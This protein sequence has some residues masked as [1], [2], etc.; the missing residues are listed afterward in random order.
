M[1]SVDIPNQRWGRSRGANSVWHR[2][3]VQ[4]VVTVFV[5]AW[6][7]AAAQCPPPPVKPVQC[8]VTKDFPLFEPTPGSVVSLANPLRSDARGELKIVVLGDSV[9]WGDGL[10]PEEK[11]VGLFGREIADLTDREVHVIS[12]AHSGARLHK[13]DDMNSV[14]HEIDGHPIGDLDSQRPTT[15]EQHACAAAAVPDPEIVL[16]DGC[17]NDVGATKIALPFPFNFTSKKQIATDAAACGPEMQALVE[18]TARQYTHATIVVINYYR[19]VSQQSAP[20]F[21]MNGPENGTPADSAVELGLEQQKLIA[22][23]GQKAGGAPAYKGQLPSNKGAWFQ[24]WSYNSDAFLATSQDCFSWATATNPH[25]SGPKCRKQYPLPYHSPA[26]LD[27]SAATATERIY[28]ATVPDKPEYAYGATESHIWLLPR[29]DRPDDMYIE[30][31]QMCAQVFGGDLVSQYKCSINAIAHPNVKGAQ[32]Y[33]DS[34][35]SLFKKAWAAKALPPTPGGTS[36][37]SVRPDA[38]N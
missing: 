16:L 9:M 6:L 38:Q 1:T 26:T 2:F 3:T 17:I 5:F 8:E 32:A 11:F 23:N 18:N 24:P 36:A 33:R 7:P 27:V 31:K 19:V 10:K 29:D 34:L 22:E 14:M 15:E 13:I 12:F 4:S 30:R 37:T 35:V 25:N 21:K 20:E 28:L